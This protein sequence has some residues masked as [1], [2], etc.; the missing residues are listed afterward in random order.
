MTFIIRFEKCVL[1]FEVQRDFL[2]ILYIIQLVEVFGELTTPLTI[3][4]AYV[5]V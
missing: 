2:R 3:L 5:H 1:L 4:L